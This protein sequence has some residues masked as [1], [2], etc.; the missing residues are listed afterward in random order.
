M[1]KE[2]ILQNRTE[3]F[4]NNNDTYLTIL[5][6]YFKKLF[7]G[8]LPCCMEQTST[9]QPA[10]GGLELPPAPPDTSLQWTAHGDL[11]GFHTR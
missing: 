5:R 4:N 9:P 10:G 11:T 1:N 7:H 3:H 8:T 6:F 2:N